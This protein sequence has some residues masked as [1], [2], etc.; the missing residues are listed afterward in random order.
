[1][2]VFEG[3]YKVFTCRIFPE[4]AGWR[5]ER[6][7]WILLTVEGEL[8]VIARLN[9]SALNPDANIPRLHSSLRRVVPALRLAS[10]GTTEGVPLSKAFAL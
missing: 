10:F 4:F 7:A 5:D 9:S 8:P 1:M 3:G 2:F 6:I